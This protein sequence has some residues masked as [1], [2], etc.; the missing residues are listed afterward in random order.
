MRWRR[1]RCRGC[2]TARTI[3]T[4]RPGSATK[5]AV[6]AISRDDLVGFQQ[7]WLRPDNMEIYV[8]SNL[9]L[10]E[11]MPLLEARFGG[12]AAPA[13]AK[14]VKSFTAL[15]PRPTSAAHRADRPAAVR[16]NRSSSAGN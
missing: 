11:I 14:G 13:V 5:A 7:R 12:W 6:K 3:P 16:R 10:A 15:P 9:P 4:R 2:S 8:V 1:A